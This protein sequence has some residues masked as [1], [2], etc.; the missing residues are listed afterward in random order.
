V[1]ANFTFIGTN[2]TATA[3]ANGGI[4]M[5][6]RRGTGGFYVNGI[7]ARWPRAGISLRDLE[8][9]NRAG[10]SATP[11]MTTTDLAVKNVLFVETPTMFQGANGTNIQ[12]SFDATG[13]ALVASSATTA[14]LFAAFPA[15]ID[16][17]TTEAAFDW[18]PAAASAAASGG[19]SAFTG[20]LAT[21]VATATSTGNTIA[22]TAYVGATAPGTAKWWQG[23]TKYYQ[24]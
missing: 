3:G 16:V 21:K 14:S 10:A 12:N 18:T 1:I 23:W 4:G 19:V 17:N 24:K 2:S 15:T 9:Y 22:G 7:V 6:L 20:K 5:M 13:N 11:N 8:T